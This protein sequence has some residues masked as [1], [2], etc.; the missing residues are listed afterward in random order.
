MNKSFFIIFLSILF[1]NSNFAQTNPQL[2]KKSNVFPETPFFVNDFE[3][4]FAWDE[5]PIIDEKLETYFNQSHHKI[6]LVTVSSIEPY[7]DIFNY[8]LDLAKNINV[9]QN[10]NAEIVIVIS[11]NL[12]Q[13]QIQNVDQIREKLTDEETKNIIENYIIP[14]FKND[15]YL[16]GIM[17]GIEQI[18]NELK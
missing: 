11:K 13:I 15:K 2:E 3:N 16:T 6:I 8:S 18:K 1:A 14:E 12:R 4:I 7:E 10:K 9:K 5:V 17:N